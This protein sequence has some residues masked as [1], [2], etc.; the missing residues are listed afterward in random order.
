MDFQE[1]VAD[2]DD[3]DEGITVGYRIRILLHIVKMGLISLLQTLVG[4]LLAQSEA[5]LAAALVDEQVD[6]VARHTGVMLLEVLQCRYGHLQARLIFAPCAFQARQS[7]GDGS[8][9]FQ[10]L[11]CIK[12][13]IC[14]ACI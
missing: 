10:F 12:G 5:A 8:I 7:A 14:L 9:D 3:A 13:N 4:S 6:V 2:I 1:V 11:W